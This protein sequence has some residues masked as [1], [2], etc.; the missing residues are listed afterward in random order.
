MWFGWL[1][2]KKA[3]LINRKKNGCDRSGKEIL[4]GLVRNFSF[5]KEGECNTGAV[6]CMICVVVAS[7]CVVTGYF[8]L[9][10]VIR[11]ATRNY[12]EGQCH[13][14][15]GV[16]HTPMIYECDI[17]EDDMGTKVYPRFMATA[18]SIS[19]EGYGTVPCD[20]VMEPSEHRTCDAMADVFFDTGSSMTCYVP[21]SDLP[22]SAADAITELSL[23]TNTCRFASNGMCNDGGPGSESII[24]GCD[25][26]TDCA[27]CGDRP[28]WP[29]CYDKTWS[30]LDPEFAGT[31]GA[32]IGGGIF[33]FPLVL[34]IFLVA[35]WQCHKDPNAFCRNARE[36]FG[37]TWCPPR[38]GDQLSS[39]V[40]R[41]MGG[42]LGRRADR[43][44]V[45]GVAQA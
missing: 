1:R 42:A 2:S 37:D 36:L 6:V 5:A 7:F 31:L 25:L 39:C 14:N 40:N 43:V 13:T 28:I 3:S 11:L 4:A 30:R 35:W 9:Y 22:T 18:T 41:L 21:G 24:S 19:I 29:I 45:T 23:C 26:G 12:V 27:D 10:G 20:F 34:P 44:T 32:A 15:I 16:N 33:F 17:Y 38:R 8:G